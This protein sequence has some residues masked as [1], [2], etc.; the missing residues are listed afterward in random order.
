MTAPKV[1]V[2]IPTFNRVRTL[3]RA[4][5]SALAQRFED[6][7]E[8]IVVDNASDDGTR[9][10]MQSYPAVAFHQ[11][12]ENVGPLENWR[13]GIELA[14]AEWVKV[15][16]SDDWL[17]ANCV[18]ELHDAAVSS[19]AVVATCRALIHFGNK[20][21]A[22][23]GESPSTFQAAQVIDA[24]AGR[25]GTLPYSP[26]AGLV[27]RS[28]ALAG[29]ASVDRESLCARKAIGPDVA[30]LYWGVL[31]GG[32]GVHVPRVLAHFDGTGDSITMTEHRSLL[33]ACYDSSFVRLA[34]LAGSP[35]PPEVMRLVRHHA[36]VSRH[37][38]APTEVLQD[39]RLSLPELG[40]SALR[41]V[42]HR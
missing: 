31:T 27:R 15:L 10:L 36:A 19:G 34:A 38:G 14:R 2:V 7:I 18:Q 26:A 30:L 1:S 12:P 17:E 33:S 24:I 25:A 23:Y 41:R 9:E 13:R 6:E 4:I 42:V 22:S 11:W 37:R 35:V 5:E 32:H 28:D 3:A 29:L 40:R 8:V 39:P 20:D 21:V 16:W